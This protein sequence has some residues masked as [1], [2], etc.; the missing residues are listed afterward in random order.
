[1]LS[2]REIKFV[3]RKRGSIPSINHRTL[4]LHLPRLKYLLGQSDIFA[5]FGAGKSAS[6]SAAKKESANMS[7]A[8]SRRAAV[9][10]DLDDDEKAIVVEEEN[11]SATK[12][13]ILFKQPNLV[14]GGAMR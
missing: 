10:D 6:D 5:H 2:L 1:M 12:S 8:G 13:T 7:R 11:E 4:S 3:K 9:T 14:S